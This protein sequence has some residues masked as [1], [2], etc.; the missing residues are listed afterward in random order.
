MPPGRTAPP[1]AIS[2][3]LGTR[4]FHATGIY[5]HFYRHVGAEDQISFIFPDPRFVVGI[6]LNRGRRGFSER[7][8]RILNTLRPHLVQA[9][10]NAEDSPGSSARGGH[11]GPG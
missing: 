11:G 4:E 3:F 7:D 2:D 1:Y 5:Q 6:A 9:Y 10:R 8:R